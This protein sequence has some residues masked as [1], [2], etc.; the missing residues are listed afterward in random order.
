MEHFRSG[1][2]ETPELRMLSSESPAGMRQM[3]TWHIRNEERTTEVITNTV[4]A[5]S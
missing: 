3:E 4:F 1:S 2:G 5:S